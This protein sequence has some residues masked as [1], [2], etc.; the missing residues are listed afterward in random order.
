MCDKKNMK[1]NK[2]KKNI[3][4]D[5]KASLCS[6]IFFMFSDVYIDI[7]LWQLLLYLFQIII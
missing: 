3:K 2:K 6:I 1:I 5:T 4:L 7:D